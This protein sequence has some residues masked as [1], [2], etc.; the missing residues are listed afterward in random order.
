MNELE[1]ITSS[2]QAPETRISSPSAAR[3]IACKLWDDDE[4]RRR[5]RGSVQGLADGNR[6]Y[7][8]EKLREA[9]QSF[10]TNV[11]WREAE[12][13]LQQA[14]SAFYDIFA[15]TENYATVD[16][17]LDNPED[18]Q[19]ASALL[20]EE[21]DKLQKS[22]DT[23]DYTIQIGLYNM[24]L[25]GVGPIVFNDPTS[26]MCDV[27]N[28]GS[29]LVPSKTKSHTGKWEYAVIKTSKLPSEIYKHIKNEA[30]AAAQGWDIEEARHLMLN[31][32]HSDSRNRQQDWEDYQEKIRNNDLFIDSHSDEIDIYNI[33]YKE[34]DGT[35]SQVMVSAT[36][37]SG[38]WLYRK[39]S[40][41]KDWDQ[42]IHPFYYDRG[43]GTHHSVKGLGVKM[44]SALE[45]KNRLTCATVDAAFQQ[46]QTL[47]SPDDSDS[48]QQVSIA[49]M[50]PYAV[51]PPGF[52]VQQNRISGVLEGPIAVGRQL[53]STLQSN[54]SQYRQRLENQLGANPR[55]ATEIQAIVAQASTLGKTQLQRF[56]EQLDSFYAERFKRALT[57]SDPAAKEF[58]AKVKDIGAGVLKKA[59]VLA[60]RSVGAGSASFRQLILQGLMQ[61]FP[62]MP[63]SGRKSLIR[64]IISATA[65]YSKVKRYMPGLTE[66]PT[67]MEA[68]YDAVLEN[69]DLRT[70]GTVPVIE[71]QLHETHAQVHIQAANQAIEA[72]QAGGDAIE[73]AEFLSAITEHTSIHAQFIQDQTVSKAILEQ[74]SELSKASNE[75]VR[76][77]QANEDQIAEQQ[78][79]MNEEQLREAQ[80]QAQ[81]AREDAKAAAQIAREDKRAES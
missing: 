50:G 58:Q 46:A 51:L 77:A 3:A 63:E 79:V 20:T 2:G 68:I 32:N 67:T 55:S 49:Q 24:V 42:I 36:N 66:D 9:N 8:P 47:L 1:N 44:F 71:T 33:F 30:S 31:S 41:Y 61:Y 37:D 53:E 65:G 81:I 73:I 12:S 7:D 62:M 52:S 39:L 38:R 75:L 70:G 16:V 15:E 29:L 35:I 14:V 64:D 43:T 76:L 80:V 11:N 57:A 18:T 23:F 56:Y 72:L 59:K 26:W 60:T 10:R 5:Q 27:I 19:R 13:F 21:F 74:L 54:L 45:I 4:E 48:A 22:D 6:P 25:H 28:A 69:N 17:E 34:F 78:S 40:K